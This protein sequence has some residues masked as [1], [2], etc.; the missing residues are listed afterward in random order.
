MKTIINIILRLFLFFVFLAAVSYFILNLNKE[1]NIAG[2]ALLII[3]FLFVG[4]AFGFAGLMKGHIKLFRI[5]GRTGAAALFLG[6]LFLILYVGG[7]AALNVMLVGEITG[8]DFGAKEK[9]A[10]LVEGFSQDDYR[11]GLAAVTYEGLTIHYPAQD[12]ENITEIKDLYPKMK[13]EADALFGVQRADALTVVVYD[14]WESLQ[15]NTYLS[16]VGGYYKASDDSIHI[17]SSKLNSAWQFEEMFAHEYIHYRTDLFMEA[18]DVPSHKIPQWVY[19]GIAESASTWSGYMDIKH[20]RGMDLSLI[21]TNQ[22]FHQARGGIYNP[23]LQSYYAV[24]ELLFQHGNDIMANL[25]LSAKNKDFGPA[26]EKVTGITL[27]EFGNSYMDRRRHAGNLLEKVVE[28]QKNKD[29]HQAELLLKE[30]IDIAPDSMASQSLPHVYIKQH[31]FAEA[32]DRIQKNMRADSE[33]A[34][35]NLLL[36]SELF[37]LENPQLALEYAE[38]A[39]KLASKKGVPGGHSQKFATALQKINSDDPLEGYVMLFSEDLLSYDEV[40]DQLYAKVAAAYSLDHRIA[41]A[42][43]DGR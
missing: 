41:T 34:Q 19:E 28:A 15:S 20:K 12:E 8:K 2:T 40:Q 30:V 3:L 5:K 29:F 9:A 27:K 33:P 16:D 23:Y 36:L 4:L 25:L 18:N 10:F 42:I 11:K 24:E 35:S 21:E 37:L 32:I 13:A 39:E 17:L 1:M 6:S 14:S 38:K 22:Q 7:L 26:F 43:E 31:K